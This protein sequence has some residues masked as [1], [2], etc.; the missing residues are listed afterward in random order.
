MRG[1]TTRSIHNIIPAW[2]AQTRHQ[3]IISQ[4]DWSCKK[5]LLLWFDLYFGLLSRDWTRPFS[6]IYNTNI[7]YVVCS[8]WLSCTSPKGMICL[9][10]KDTARTIL[11][12]CREAFHLLGLLFLPIT[13]LVSHVA[14]LYFCKWIFWNIFLCYINCFS[15]EFP[16]LLV[17]SFTSS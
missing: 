17:I 7:V 13:T 9:S 14:L 5:I 15:P 2:S 12:E 3:Y 1:L 16:P 11:L 8:C 6:N 10:T 4:E